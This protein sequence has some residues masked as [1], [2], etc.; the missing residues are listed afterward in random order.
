MR[1]AIYNEDHKLAGQECFDSHPTLSDITYH[2]VTK[3]EIARL[4]FEGYHASESKHRAV[5]GHCLFLLNCA[6]T[7]SQHYQP[8]TPDCGA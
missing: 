7:L 3:T 4:E 2:H 6:K 5:G 1:I 8:W